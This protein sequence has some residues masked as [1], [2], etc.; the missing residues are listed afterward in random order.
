M[1]REDLWP[2]DSPWVREA[3]ESLPRDLFAPRTVWIWTGE[4]YEAVDRAD[5]PEAWAAAV[6]P[7]PYGSTVTQ[8]TGGMPT[9]SISCAATMLDFLVL[10]PVPVL[11]V[12]YTDRLMADQD[13][14]RY[15][16][17]I[18]EDLDTVTRIQIDELRPG[19]DTST[20]CRM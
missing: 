13:D 12:T 6:H 18:A 10:E 9:S 5:A 3:M 2:A 1:D 14:V 20:G 15:A 11:A 4:H 17:R 16:Q 8:V 19:L 7:G